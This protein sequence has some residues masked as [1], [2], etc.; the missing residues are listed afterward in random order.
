MKQ[1]ETRWTPTFAE[2]WTRYMPPARPSS[3]EIVLYTRYLRRLQKNNKG[4]IKVLILGSTPELRDWGYQEDLDV[5]VVD[6][7]A[8][9][10]KVLGTFMRHKDLH[11]HFVVSDWKDMA[12]DKKFDIIIGDHAISVV[13]REQVDS[14]LRAIANALADKGLFIT[15][16]YLRLK[17]QKQRAL[18]TIIAEYYK[19]FSNYNLFL[20]TTGIV[21]AGTDPE[22]DY[23]SFSKSLHSLEELWQKGKLKKE[24]LEV[25]ARLNW[26]Q[27]KY[28]LYCPTEEDWG[29]RYRQ[30]FTLHKKDYSEDI[31]TKDMPIYVLKRK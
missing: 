9:N 20:F 21:T 23:F 4:K 29:K 24:H 28:D 6:Y 10:Y 12:F 22:T 5:T 25:F 14:V 27:M 13:Q 30:Y 8:E 31:Y 2:I 15:K 7:N 1:K 16:H 17:G 18:E 3:A 11:E 19:K 26:A